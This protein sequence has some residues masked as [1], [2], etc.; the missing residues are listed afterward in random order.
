[1][2]DDFAVAAGLLCA[3]TLAI[4]PLASLA[5][6]VSTR[7]KLGDLVRRVS[8]SES[9]VARLNGQVARLND[10]VG[11]LRAE[12]SLRAS[13][14]TASTA[15]TAAPVA[16]PVA[17]P[18]V[19]PAVEAAARSTEP[20]TEPAAASATAHAPELASGATALSPELPALS[21]AG[22]S[23]ISEQPAPA[24][25]ASTAGVATAPPSATPPVLSERPAPPPRPEPRQ[26][27][28]PPSVELMGT[29]LFAALGGLLVLVGGLLFF[30]YA[31]E[32]GWFG[33]LGPG[34]RFALGIAAGLG[35][36]VGGQVLHKR[37]YRIPAAAFGG[38]GL[39]I[40]YGAL[41]AG[42]TLY[43][44]LDQPV[45]FAAMVGVTIA[46]G[47]IAW[48]WRS[49]FL[50][51]LGL[52]GGLLTP[53]LLSTGQN[54]AM[55][56][57][58]YLAL[59]NAGAVW[60]ASAR[61]WPITAGLAAFGTLAIQMG[62]AEKYGAMDQIPIGLGA[63]AVFAAIYG[64]SAMRKESKLGIFSAM[65]L[66]TLGQALAVL[67]MMLTY[68]TVTWEGSSFGQ[69]FH[70]PGVAPWMSSGW[71]VLFASWL[72]F[73]AQR[74]GS[75]FLGVG[76]VAAVGLDQ[77]VLGGA[78]GDA[79][80]GVVSQDH[81]L[82]AMIAL[83]VLAPSWTSLAVGMGGDKD[84]AVRTWTPALAQL[85]GSFASMMAIASADAP[86][87]LVMAATL[88]FGLAGVVGEQRNPW[89]PLVGLVAAAMPLY[90]GMPAM[91]SD[92]MLSSVTMAPLAVVLIV[93]AVPLLSK[94]N[95]QLGRWLASAC[96]GPIF[97]LPLHMAWDEAWGS[98]YIGLLPILL[99]ILSM[100]SAVYVRRI[101][102]AKADDRKLAL[103]ITVATL[104]A[105]VAVPV[106]LSRHW[107]VLGWAMESAV[108]AW[109]G[110]R[111]KHPGVRWFA[112]AMAVGALGRLAMDPYV[113]EIPARDLMVVFNLPGLTYAVTGVCLLVAAR[114]LAE[115]PP[116]IPGVPVPTLLRTAAT[117]VFFVGLNVEVSLAFAEDGIPRAGGT[118]GQEMF[119]SII[120]AVYGGILL[121]LGVWRDNSGTRLLAMGFLL[122]AAAKVFFWDLWDLEGMFRVAS[123]LGAAMTLLGSAVLLQR[124]VLRQRSTDEGGQ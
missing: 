41:Y 37:E 109:L 32:E 18:D 121:G 21:Q 67:P 102:V 106:Q 56:L 46:S 88:M 58:S 64:V 27:A 28:K 97:Y 10:A 36:L 78:W 59:L 76:A 22:E 12:A 42:R 93:N 4:A 19:A 111:L 115:G 31:L 80:G 70:D 14:T 82:Y 47:L 98:D 17:A 51:T 8:E 7:G 53:I 63:G 34:A 74:K 101:L 52:I 123:V 107:L 87:L 43:D 30:N 91:M 118:F 1:M 124:V 96:A 9:E 26:P 84:S 122:L 90:A 57:F 105:C 60:V 95:D 16:A 100:V 81:S 103:L 77:M 83:A 94:Q 45:T 71:I 33:R 11:R 119:R 116:L 117:L 40:L 38:G 85:A 110:L 112:L 29:W 13:L 48:R 69:V 50:S 44:L 24:A 61:N 92:H 108:L 75:M 49:Q 89:S 23:P 62:W 25:D 73:I 15:T 65:S 79:M 3:G 39:G 20:A 2:S 113:V 55:A 86:P 104:F 114:G 5:L 66:G 6:A 99:G 72:Y 120:W 35:A 54:K 68:D